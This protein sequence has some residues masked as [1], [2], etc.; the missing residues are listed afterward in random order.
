MWRRLK[1]IGFAALLSVTACPVLAQDLPTTD[2]PALIQAEEINFDE[3]L[4]VITA[5]G[6][7]EITQNDRVLQAD[8]VSY[9]FNI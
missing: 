9:N 8:A 5:K 7:V 4:G 3:N 1:Q 2:V 6:N